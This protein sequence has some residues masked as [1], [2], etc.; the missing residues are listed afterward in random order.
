MG[1]YIRNFAD[2]PRRRTWA[3]YQGTWVCRLF[4]VILNVG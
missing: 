1:S 4:S 3:L 2:L